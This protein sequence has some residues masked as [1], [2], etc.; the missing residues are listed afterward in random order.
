MLGICAVDTV[1]GCALFRCWAALCRL[2]IAVRHCAP[3][4]PRELAVRPRVAPP[5]PRPRCVAAPTAGPKPAVLRCNGF[6]PAP[7]RCGRPGAG[8]CASHAGP[9]AVHCPGGWAAWCGPR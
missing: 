1:L 7:S 2:S 3:H 5:H 8:P 9:F 4:P 6:P